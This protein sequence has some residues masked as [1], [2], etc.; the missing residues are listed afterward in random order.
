MSYESLW[1]SS[2]TDGEPPYCRRLL[3]LRSDIKW[4]AS[5]D[6]AVSIAEGRAGYRPV[7][8]HTALSPAEMY[9]YWPDAPQ[10]N[11]WELHAGGSTNAAIADAMQY[12]RTTVSNLL[13]RP[14]SCWWLIPGYV[15]DRASV[16]NKAATQCALAA[17]GGIATRGDIAGVLR[18]WRNSGHWRRYI[19]GRRPN[20]CSDGY[21]AWDRRV[22]EKRAHAR[23]GPSVAGYNK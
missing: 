12:S 13:R 2:C 5:I 6:L 15:C 18:R 4:R 3:R 19:S 16:L 22:S 11:P 9:W 20:K 21:A 8:R 1:Y 14:P 10:A 17:N 23:R 7:F